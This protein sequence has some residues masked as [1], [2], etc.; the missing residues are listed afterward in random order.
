MRYIFSFFMFLFATL[1]Q[2]SLVNIF[3]VFNITPNIVLCLVVMFSFLYNNEYHGLI[4]GTV[5]GLISDVI[6]M[7]FT[8]VSALGYFLISL[9]VIFMSDTFNR[10]NMGTAIT[11]RKSVV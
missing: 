3:A 5:F 11:D 7:P 6:Y 4:W 8:G 9:F 10:E 2:G 1:F